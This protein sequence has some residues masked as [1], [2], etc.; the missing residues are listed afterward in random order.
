MTTALLAQG[1]QAHAQ[2]APGSHHQTVGS[3]AGLAAQVS[4]TGG[5][6]ASVPLN[7]PTPR[8]RVPVPLSINYTGLG[9]AGAA[10]VGWDIPIGYVAWETPERTRPSVAATDG[11]RPPRLLLSV[12]GS[13]QR[14]LQLDDAGT[15][16]A[17]FLSMRYLDLRKDGDVWHLRTLDNLEY[18]FTRRAGGTT[19]IWL[20]TEVRDLVGTDRVVIEYDRT[21]IGS[22]IPDLHPKRYSYGWSTSVPAQPLYQVELSYEGWWRPETRSQV[23]VAHREAEPGCPS[24]A[25]SCSTL[26]SIHIWT[27]SAPRS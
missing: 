16:F 2:L 19:D 14:M 12:D 1:G 5:F 7:L 9:R 11:R 6:S 13:P 25:R 10:G 8:G 22:C 23:Q 18:V 24:N 21:G 15:R 20:L 27:L 17:P 26:L 4:P 3:G